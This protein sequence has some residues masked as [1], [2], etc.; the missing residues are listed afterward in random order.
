MFNPDRFMTSDGE[1]SAKVCGAG[2]SIPTT[3]HNITTF[4]G[5]PR[6]CLGFRLAVLELKAALFVLLRSFEFS[7]IPGVDIKEKMV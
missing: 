2:P 3:W 5:G 7:E 4:F 1:E 6:I